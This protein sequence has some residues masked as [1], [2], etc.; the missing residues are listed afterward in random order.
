MA[1]KQLLDIAE[2]IWQETLKHNPSFAMMSGVHD[3]DDQLEDPSREAELE[4]IEKSEGFLRQI[5]A[6]DPSQLSDRRKVTY[7]I[8]RGGAG[9]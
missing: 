1:E 4:Q 7:G 9:E 6:I 5:K 2:K 3:Y 8:L